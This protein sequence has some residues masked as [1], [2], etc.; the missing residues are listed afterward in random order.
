MPQ[1]V[2]SDQ[3]AYWIKLASSVAVFAATTMILAKAYAWFVTDSA[4]MLASLTDSFFDVAASVF[5]FFALRY[6]LKPADKEHK[7]GHGKAEAL[8]GLAQ[9]AF[10][11]GSA[12]LLIFH[13]FGRLSNPQP[14]LQIEAATWA[15]LFAIAVTLALVS[16]QQIAIRK[17]NSVAIQADSLHYK[18]DLLMNVAVLVALGLTHYGFASMDAWFAIGIALYLAHSAYEV[19]HQSIQSLMDQELPDS[20][21]DN[22]RSIVTAHTEVLGLHDLR[23]RQSGKTQFIQLHMELPDDLI[24][25]D[26]HRI[27]EQVEAKLKAVYPLADIIIHQDPISSVTTNKTSKT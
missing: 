24:L 2:N 21:I 16:V 6:A 23:T 8:A 11:L 22:I 18:G 25:I 27:A 5:N 15:T 12:T 20:D 26:A 17:T 4:T 9:A 19:G 14:L 13:S 10:I 7:F 3:Y 1:N